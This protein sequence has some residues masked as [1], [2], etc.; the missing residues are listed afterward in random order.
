MFKYKHEYLYNNFIKLT[1]NDKSV[2]VFRKNKPYIK[3]KNYKIRLYARGVV[4][5]CLI[6]NVV[7]ITELHSVYY[8]IAIN[9]FMLKYIV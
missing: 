3:N 4:L 9:P 1:K 2:S 7:L 6:L 8:S 5:F